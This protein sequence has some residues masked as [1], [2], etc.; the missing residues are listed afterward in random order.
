MRAVV[1][2]DFIQSLVMVLFALIAAVYITCNVSTSRCITPGWMA[3]I[4]FVAACLLYFIQ[5]LTPRAR[6]V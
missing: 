3:R 4:V 5:L 1:W 6:S 2:T